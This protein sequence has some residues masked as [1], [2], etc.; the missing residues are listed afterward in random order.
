MGLRLP[1]LALLA[2]AAKQVF[3]QG[4]V[5]P[6]ATQ[7]EPTERTGR[8]R[9]FDPDDGQLDL[10]YFLENPRG[11]LPI[12]IV[13]TEPAVG[14]GGGAGGLFLRPHKEAGA[15]GWARPDISGVGGFATQNGTWAAF[16]W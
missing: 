3:A 14:Y 11:F 4:T 16:Y 1:A 9:F 7:T 15:E 13:I 5:E 2:T 12:P 6:P 10:S 8:A